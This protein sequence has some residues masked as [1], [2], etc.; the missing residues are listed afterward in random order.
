MFSTRRTRRH[1]HSTRIS[2]VN[3]NIA[4]GVLAYLLRPRRGRYFRTRMRRLAKFCM[5][6]ARERWRHSTKFRTVA[7]MAHRCDPTVHYVGGKLLRTDGR[8]G[9]HHTNW[10]NIELAL[11]WID[12]AGDL[13]GDGSWSTAASK[14]G[15]VH[16][17]GK[18]RRMPCFMQMAARR[19]ALC[20]L[21]KC[22][23]MCLPP[24][25]ARLD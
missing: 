11:Q 21:L 17:G 15:L 14:G 7:T 12:S 25:D 4:R 6:H 22:K 23:G 20:A 18:T 19:R 10:P 16:Q 8:S 5:R 1:H 3:P 13:D 2:V 24:S 9:L